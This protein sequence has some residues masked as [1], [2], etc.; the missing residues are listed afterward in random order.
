TV[1]ASTFRFSVPGGH[2]G[3][4]G[5][6]NVAVLPTHRRRGVLTALMREQLDDIRRRGE[7]LACLWAS[8]S[9]IY[10]HFGYGLA[11]V[12]LS[13]EIAR[14]GAAFQPGVAAGL[15]VR[16]VDDDQLGPA[17][18]SVHE[19]LWRTRPGMADRPPSWLKSRLR[20]LRQ[21]RQ[22]VVDG[23]SGVEAYAS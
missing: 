19:R 12:S 21:L 2:L 13:W 16:L 18:A 10:P 14:P 15:P 4:A 3:A 5:V 17:M 20:R 22:A 23:P 1:Q 11:A 9:R 7:P 8:E 6:R